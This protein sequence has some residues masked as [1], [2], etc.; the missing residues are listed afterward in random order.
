MIYCTTLFIILAMLIML[1]NFFRT[2]NFLSKIVCLNSIVSYI[3][4]LT[5]FLAVVKK[6]PYYLDLSIVY[7][8]LGGVTSIGFL[9]YCISTNQK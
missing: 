9:K 7:A 5:A 3:V 1:L 6:Y 8:L 2:K 4:I